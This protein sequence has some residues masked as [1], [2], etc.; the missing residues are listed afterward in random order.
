MLSPTLCISNSLP[1]LSQ[2]VDPVFSLNSELHLQVMTL[3]EYIK[4]ELCVVDLRIT[5]ITQDDIV[6]TDYR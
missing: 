1:F 4:V 3:A 5:R 2:S 6:E